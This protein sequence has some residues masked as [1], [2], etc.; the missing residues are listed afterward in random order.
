M[1]LVTLNIPYSLFYLWR[2]DRLPFPKLS[3]FTRCTRY[4]DMIYE[5]TECPTLRLNRVEMRRPSTGRSRKEDIGYHLRLG[6]LT[7]RYEGHNYFPVMGTQNKKAVHVA[8]WRITVSGQ[9]S[10][11]IFWEEGA[12][13]T[14]AHI[15]RHIILTNRGWQTTKYFK[16]NPH[17]LMYRPLGSNTKTILESNF[18]Q[19]DRGAMIYDSRFGWYD[20]TSYA[21]IE[22]DDRIELHDVTNI[23]EYRG[24]TY[25]ISAGA[26]KITNL[27]TMRKFV[28]ALVERVIENQLSLPEAVEAFK[29]ALRNDG[30][31]SIQ[32]ARGST[33]LDAE[34]MWRGL[35]LRKF[36]KLTSDK[37][38]VLR[39]LAN[40]VNICQSTGFTLCSCSH[41]GAILYT[42]VEHETV[43]IDMNQY[44]NDTDSDFDPDDYPDE[45][46]VTYRFCDESH[47]LQH[48]LVARTASIPQKHGYHTD[49]LRFIP[50]GE[51]ARPAP[52]GELR[53]C[54][55]ELETFHSE[56]SSTEL[57]P[58]IVGGSLTK[59]MKDKVKKSSISWNQET[60]NHFGAIPTRDGS[61]DARYGVEWVFRPSDLNGLHKDVSQFMA[62]TQGYIE[63]D[64]DACD[65]N[66][67]TYGLHVHVTATD[68]MRSLPTRVR[69]AMVATRLDTIFH[70]IGGR[71]YTN[72]TRKLDSRFLLNHQ[73]VQERRS[74]WQDYCGRTNKPTWLKY[75]KPSS[76][77]DNGERA[78]LVAQRTIE[79]RTRSLPLT[80]NGE[81]LL[82]GMYNNNLFVRYNMTNI[83]VRRP[84]IEFRHGRSY[85]DSNYIMLNTELSQAVALFG[86]YEVLSVAQINYETLPYRFRDYVFRNRKEYPRLAEW[87]LQNMSMSLTSNSSNRVLSR[88]GGMYAQ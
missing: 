25:P 41:C 4:T 37:V 55:I 33:V 60:Y 35:Y 44:R 29:H 86:S 62:M 78:R 42:W 77:M 20:T 5:I 84:T 66:N 67:R 71:G 58:Y 2:T 51:S 38:H 17:L 48:N 11:T 1:N 79:G 10:D 13:T 76:I 82:E 49:V 68:T 23:F 36:A 54:G 31:A 87:F 50:M 16:D 9:H 70:A 21:K 14:G 80:N 83:S 19:I 43:Q 24:N 63:H 6:D 45:D 39:E 47:A 72:Y 22:V 65:N 15:P 73:A 61:L 3:S 81:D 18:R 32:L 57:T 59:K 75:I 12:R 7:S 52:H 85:V 53:R 28:R 27:E 8:E 74:A 30:W 34:T 40:A 64:A 46:I 26:Y 56:T 88:L 69:V